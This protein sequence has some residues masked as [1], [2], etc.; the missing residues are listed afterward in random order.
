MDYPHLDIINQIREW[1]FANSHPSFIHGIE[2]WDRVFYNG[3]KLLTPEVNSLVVGVFAYVHDSCRLN[4]GRDLEHGPRASEKVDEIRNTVL[5]ALNDDEILLLKE[6][7]M[8]HTS[9]P[10]TGNPTIDACFDADRLDLLRVG[11][12]PDPER[13]ATKLGAKIAT[14]MMSF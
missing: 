3:L 7:C 6:A 2:H 9:T 11:I 4:D 8:K 14:Q 12:Q 1:A 13:M 5:A 10:K